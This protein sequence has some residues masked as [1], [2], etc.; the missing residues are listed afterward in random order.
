MRADIVTEKR[1][2]ISFLQPVVP[3]FLFIS[4]TNRKVA[5]FFYFIIYNRAISKGRANYCVPFCFQKIK[6]FIN[7]G[8]LNYFHKQL[9]FDRIIFDK[10]Q[11]YLS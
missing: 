9:N 1:I 8:C 5:G 4:I 10:F 6:N 2:I 11:N 7:C 3:G